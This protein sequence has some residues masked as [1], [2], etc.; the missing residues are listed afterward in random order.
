VKRTRLDR[1]LADDEEV[2]LDVRPQG[3]VLVRPALVLVVSCGLFSLAA[4]RVPAG[5]AQGLA[6]GVVLAV[7]L[8][9]VSRAA[10]WPFLQWQATRYVVTTRRVMLRHGVL[11]RSG[12][13]LPLGRITDASFRQNPLDRLLG[14]GTLTLESAGERGRLVLTGVPDVQGVQREVHALADDPTSRSRD[15]A[16]W[17]GA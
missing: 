12:R 15:V 16:P 11:S 10:L 9:V 7:G 5:G 17:S 14:C 8:L 1:H 4:S 6:R 2:V 13:D 3:K